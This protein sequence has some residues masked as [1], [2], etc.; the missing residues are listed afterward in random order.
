MDNGGSLQVLGSM[1]VKMEM[2]DM[3][4]LVPGKTS[5][6]WTHAD[7][8]ALWI[9]QKSRGNGVW[10]C[11]IS[12]DDLDY[13]GTT[14]VFTT[15]EISGAV[16][17][18]DFWDRMKS[19]TRDF[20]ENRKPG[21]IFHY[22]NSTKQFVRA[23]VVVTG[24]GFELRPIALVGNWHGSDLPRW[25]ASGHFSEGGYWVKKIKDGETFQPNESSL[26]EVSPRDTDPRTM[27]PLNIA[28][29]AP[30]A[31]QREAADMLAV[32]AEV[33]ALLEMPRQSH[34]FAE[35]YKERLAAVATLIAEKINLESIPPVTRGPRLA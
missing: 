14:R 3:A 17:A 2:L 4:D 19:E 23:E 28:T 9:V 22:H 33:Q 7:S 20:W 25:W 12:K 6:R 34:D 15:E 32:V 18:A 16:K 27:E 21:E 10:D 11:M 26:W 29:P 35:T 1:W 31:A 8:N 5:F 13:A 30:T 24:K